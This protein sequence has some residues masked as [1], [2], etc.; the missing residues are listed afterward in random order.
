MNNESNGAPKLMVGH[1]HVKV[2]RLNINERTKK[3]EVV[4]VHEGI[5]VQDLGSFVRVYSNAPI[6][7]GGDVSH[8]FA[9][10][11]PV[12]SNRV[13]CDLVSHKENAVPLA[14]LFRF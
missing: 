9:Q 12:K 3:Q 14:P 11:F 10:I 4:Q 6:E 5:V 1:S 7:K 13:W 2:M 8:E